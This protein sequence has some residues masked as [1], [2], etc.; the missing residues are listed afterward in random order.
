MSNQASL[1]TEPTTWAEFR[2]ADRALLERFEEVWQRR[3][4]WASEP[5]LVY[6]ER[7][8]RH[9]RREFNGEDLFL[10]FTHHLSR[11]LDRTITGK[12]RMK[13]HSARA[14]LCQHILTDC[15]LQDRFA[16]KV[17]HAGQLFMAWAGIQDTVAQLELARGDTH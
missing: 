13:G 8:E 11:C 17:N 6:L 9:L 16:Q 7:R 15:G 2:T 14:V 3:G 10:V 4:P 5:E 1:F 12:A